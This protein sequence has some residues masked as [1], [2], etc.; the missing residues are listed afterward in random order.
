MCTNSTVE[1]TTWTFSV[2][3]FSALKIEEF[4]S[5]EVLIP[6]NQITRHYILADDGIHCHHRVCQMSPKWRVTG[7]CRFIAPILGRVCRDDACDS[8][9]VRITSLVIGVC[10]VDNNPSPSP[11]LPSDWT[12]IPDGFRPNRLHWAVWSEACRGCWREIYELT[13]TWCRRHY[14]GHGSPSIIRE[15]KRKRWTGHVAR[16][17]RWVIHTEVSTF[18]GT[19]SCVTGMMIL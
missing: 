13:S 12:W 16:T 17:C 19:I 11:C 1:H 15:L 2:G 8:H 4:G 7:Y 9:V 14:V 18:E 6:V 10:G 3:L 5:S